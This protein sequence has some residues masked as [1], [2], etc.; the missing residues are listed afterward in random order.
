MKLFVESVFMKKCTS[1]IF[2][3]FTVSFIVGQNRPI[4]EW[5]T[6]FSY[7]NITNLQIAGTSLFCSS[8]NGL[9][10]IQDNVIT[11]LSKT[12]GLSDAGVGSLGFD[13]SHSTLL[14]GYKSGKLDLVREGSVNTIN[15]LFEVNL[16]NKRINNFYLNDNFY[17]LST[18]LGLAYFDLAQGQI[19]DVYREI[20]PDGEPVMVY[21]TTMIEN[22]VFALTDYG[23]LMGDFTKNLFDFN[24]WQ[25]LT[26]PDT[27]SIN[28]IEQ[29]NDQL[30]F[31]SS[32]NVYSYDG[33]QVEQIQ[34][35]SQSIIG[36]IQSPNDYLVTESE[37][38]AWDG[39]LFSNVLASGNFENVTSFA[40]FENKN[41]FGSS[42]QGLRILQSDNTWESVTPNGPISDNI[43]KISPL[44]EGVGLVYGSHPEGATSHNFDIFYEG[45][46]INQSSIYPVFDIIEY[47][48][49][50]LLATSQGIYNQSENQIIIETQGGNI[51]SFEERNGSLWASSY[52]SAYSLFL[53]D[54]FDWFDYSSASTG[55]KYATDVKVSLFNVAWIQKG[56][57][58]G[59]GIVAF[60]PVE[61]L[62]R[63]IS[64]SDGISASSIS[65]YEISLDDEAWIASNNNLS[66]FFDAS[67]VFDDQEAVEVLFE[68]RPLLG[69]QQI[70]SIAFDGGNRKWI[71]TQNGIWVF[72]SNLTDLVVI[73]NEEN[74]PLPSKS[75]K[76]LTYQPDDG[77][78]FIHTAKGLVSLQTNSSKPLL[79]HL[80][81]EIYPN[82]VSTGYNGQVAITKTIADASIKI[83][84]PS[85][86]LI[87]DLKA[88]GSTA[89]WDLRDYNGQSVT[90]GIY[91]IFSSDSDGI[92]TYIG[93][94]AV[95]K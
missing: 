64:N 78:M 95:E 52:D 89:S 56:L 25:Q 3:F 27:I 50:L 17:L 37:I 67:L 90:P 76:S 22:I 8:E 33:L 14:I 5:Q 41:W 59:G 60:E 28:S 81:V 65:D 34:N 54:G 23:L 29:I 9:F 58:E 88:N 82:P 46:W 83:T 63:N 15:T 55:S 1:Y 20:G 53:F 47:Q 71:G 86:Q 85:G 44:S 45:R 18:D 40:F 38:L 12:D 91:I 2:L 26:S 6:H 11:E 43:K 93:K 68:G 69:G 79:S 42:D 74:S 61:D 66:A 48:E 72:E 92:D 87:R 70:T 4:G 94:I 80:D 39:D 35:L 51:S 24:N 49:D 19:R 21:Q 13:D 75:I 77:Q 32:E 73:Y 57:E 30:I 62:F 7:N 10:Y 36:I 31:T 84:N 16:D